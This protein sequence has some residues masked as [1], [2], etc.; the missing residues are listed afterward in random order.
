[1]KN[2]SALGFWLI[3][4]S[5][6]SPATLLAQAQA[7]DDSLVIQELKKSGSNVSKPH[8]I[9]F[10]LYFP[11]RK[12]AERA[13][14]KIRKLGCSIKKIAPAASGPGWLVLAAKTMIPTESALTQLRGEFDRIARSEKGEYDGWEA[15]VVK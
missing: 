6:F 9:E 11:N 12:V 4:V 13:S 2:I 3:A 1:M 14:L 5:L 8:D 15:G 10:Y 7:S